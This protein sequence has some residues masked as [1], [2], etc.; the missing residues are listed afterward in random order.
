MTEQN[1]REVFAEAMT[2][3]HD[4]YRQAGKESE[5]MLW[6]NVNY[7]KDTISE[8]TVSVAS[9][10]MWQQM[11][12]KGNIQKIEAKIYELVGQNI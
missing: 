7:L 6:F 5:F 9:E 10:F 12:S 8:I 3:I 4:E 1:Y 2:Q 11:V